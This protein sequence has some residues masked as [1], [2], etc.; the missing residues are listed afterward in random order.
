[1]TR[2]PVRSERVFQRV[3]RRATRRLALS[4]H[5]VRV[6]ARRGHPAVRLP[7]PI[8]IDDTPPELRP[9]SGRWGFVGRLTPQKGVDRFVRWVARAGVEGVVVGTGP[10]AAPL[11]QL[12]VKLGARVTFVGA[13]SPG[14]IHALWPQLDLVVLAPRTYPDG[15]G[16]EG[17][18]LA[19]LEAAGRGV[20]AVGCRTGGVV[21]A[22]GPGLILP[23]PDDD[24]RAVATIVDWWTPERGP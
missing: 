14:Q 24:D 19:L 17:L 12:A 18:G 7:A 2:P 4:D 9:R 3:W 20:A 10:M 23:D 1:M 5:L 8:P 13:R 21:E 6:L 22:V 11:R 15:S 16:A